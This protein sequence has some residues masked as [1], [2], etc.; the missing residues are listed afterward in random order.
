M[1]GSEG[2]L[3][4]AESPEVGVGAVELVLACDRALSGYYRNAQGSE[5]VVMNM[6]FN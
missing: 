1:R 5:V 4:C 3:G 2:G 6:H